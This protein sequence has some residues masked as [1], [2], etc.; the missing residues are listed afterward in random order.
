MKPDAANPIPKRPFWCKKGPARRTIRWCRR[1]GYVLGLAVVY[2]G[3]HLNQIGL[4]GFAKDALIGL[5]RERGFEIE[6]SRMRVRLGRGIVAE[7]VN[8]GRSREVAGEQFYVDQL[9]LK[10]DWAR[11]VRFKPDIRAVTVR[12]G[13]VVIPVLDTN[14]VA[15]RFEVDDIE[16]RLRFAGPE[17]WDLESLQ[18]KTLGGRFQASGT[19]TNAGRLRRSAAPRRAEPDPWKRVLL[20]AVKEMERS[21]FAEPPVL[22]L[23]F[24]A[25]LAD[26]LHSTAECR[27]VAGGAVTGYGDYENLALTANLNQ[28]ASTNGTFSVAL[29]LDSG[30]AEFRDGALD[31]LR[32]G[33]LI[34]LPPDGGAPS[35]IDWHLGAGALRWQGHRLAGLDVAGKS[36]PAS[37]EGFR[38]LPWNPFGPL[39]GAPAPAFRSQVTVSLDG[40][41]ITNG[42]TGGPIT[43]RMDA[44]HSRLGWY[45]AG[46]SG[47]APGVNTPWIRTGPVQ[48]EAAIAPSAGKAT[49][50]PDLGAWRFLSAVEFQ[51]STTLTNA[52]RPELSVDS[53]HLRA[54]WSN[55][56]LALEDLDARL[57][58]G[59]LEASGSVETASRQATLRYRSDADPAGV[60]PLLLEVG[61][62]WMSQFG[63]PSNQPPRLDGTLAVTLPPWVDRPESWRDELKE[64]LRLDGRFSGGEFRFRGI[65][66]NSAAGQFNY[67]NRVWRIR[68]LR[69]VRPEGSVTLDYAGDE[70]TR[71]YWFSIRSTI[72]PRIAQPLIDNPVAARVF[73]EFELTIPPAIEAQVWG[74]WFEPER[75]GLRAKVHLENMSFRGEHLDSVDGGLTYTNRFLAVSKAV[76]RD[77]K[78]GADVEGFAYD[79]GA[80]MI[81]FTNA[82]STVDPARVTRVIG[83]KTHK[84]MEPYIFPEPPTVRVD[85]A[86]GIRG[87]PSR[88]SIHFDALAAPKFRWWKLN[89]HDVTASVQSLGPLLVVSN[90]N[91]GFHGGRLT[92][93]LEF[94]LQPGTPNTFR[95]DAD[96]RDANLNSLISDLSTPPGRTNQL[97]GALTAKIRITDGTTPD[98]LSWKGDGTAQL[99]DGYLWDQ[100]L[101]GALSS[102][103]SGVMPGLGKTRFNEGSAHYTLAGGRVLTRDLRLRAPSMSLAFTGSVGFARD[104]DMVVQGSLFRS[105]PF[106]GPVASL[107]LSPFEKL[108]EY[109][110][111]GSL[112]KP[113]T[114]PAHIPSLLM[115]PLNPIGTIRDLIPESRKPEVETAPNP[116]TAEP[117][118]QN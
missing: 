59:R 7:N 83:P 15:G 75:I 76:L 63:W 64:T 108:F 40:L 89:A 4:P 69:A 68:D 62:R 45:Q 81:S 112:E 106:F 96:V 54:G 16:A 102:V 38:F 24:H 25:D 20:R 85:G 43:L 94:D 66:G 80:G 82:L 109:K 110:V 21:V 30:K 56:I 118:P 47:A 65:T 79:I 116:T 26:P 22:T 50:L 6:F 104:L 1:S 60:Q 14:G 98:P 103:M 67:S 57:F 10:L 35:R 87:D 107:A 19:I 115:I 70:R 114:E 29:R 93:N 48:L 55:G 101:F 23:G 17:L 53:V 37:T 34:E 46:I 3:V 105:V 41:E 28:P 77:G 18:G 13:K 61:R 33:A 73:G 88:N 99:R 95:I 100:P 58:G 113:H 111:T 12:G 2:A 92:G 74:R 49:G 97:E 51:A 52:H 90:L 11:L 36:V 117:A 5:L 42:I 91:A 72:D 78:Q 27:L 9:Q 8:V 39:P 32:W 86:I 44:L 84:I 71:D 31:A